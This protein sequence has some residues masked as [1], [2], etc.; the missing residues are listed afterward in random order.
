MKATKFVIFFLLDTIYCCSSNNRSALMF[1][2]TM[3]IKKCSLRCIIQRQCFL[4]ENNK[5]W[6][7]YTNCKAIKIKTCITFVSYGRLLSSKLL[8][9]SVTMEALNLCYTSGQTSCPPKTDPPLFL[10]CMPVFFAFT[11][12]RNAYD[13]MFLT[14]VTLKMKFNDRSQNSRFTGYCERC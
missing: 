14:N 2:S 13:F 8:A 3:Q 7:T 9:D 4:Y 10:K 6:I 5:F 12:L 1:K 11:F